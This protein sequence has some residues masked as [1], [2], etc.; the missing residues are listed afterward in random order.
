MIKINLNYIFLHFKNKK[1]LKNEKKKRF[2]S[3]NE[4]LILCSVSQI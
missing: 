3:E 2:F 4:G 1:K